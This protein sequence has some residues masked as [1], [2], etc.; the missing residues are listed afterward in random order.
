MIKLAWR[1]GVAEL[2]P[3]SE[4][5]NK[6]LY[7]KKRPMIGTIR[8]KGTYEDRTRETYVA[9]KQKALE[10]SLRAVA[11]RKMVR[12]SLA[13]RFCLFEMMAANGSGGISRRVECENRVPQ[14]IDQND[15]S[16]SIIHVIMLY[17]CI[18]HQLL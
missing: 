18:A 1:F 13:F 8:P 2:L 10:E 12:T 6:L 9:K 4:K 14:W 15:I 11:M 5:M 7:G 3:P 16:D 17:Q